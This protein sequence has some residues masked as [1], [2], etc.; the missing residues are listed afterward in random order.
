VIKYTILM[1]T[2]NRLDDVKRCFYHLEATLWRREVKLMVLDN[3]STD[4]VADY[5][6]E[7][8]R[9]NWMDHPYITP[10]NKGVAEGR[11]FLLRRLPEPTEYVVFL[12]SDTAIVDPN[13]LDVLGSVLDKN[14]NIGMVGPG[15]SFVLPDW[16]GFT[17]ALPN[18]E[19][20][21]VAGY[22]QMFRRSLLDLGVA[23]DTRYEKFWAEDSDFCMQIRDKGWDVYCQPVG[24]MHYP[25]HSGYG[26]EPGLH[27]AHI[28]LFRETWQGKGLTR[29]E[30]A[31]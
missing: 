31:Y 4:G 28:K 8:Q 15:G 17:A 29:A 25:S 1:L 5:L 19:C 12:D 30:G 2:H 13:W 23:M 21:C 3:G 22:C 11:A 10:I 16:S 6:H 7:L 27:D 9:N 24:V 20:D 26:Q 14:E 18:A